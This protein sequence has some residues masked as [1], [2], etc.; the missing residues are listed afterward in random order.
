MCEMRWALHLLPA[1]EALLALFASRRPDVVV[2]GE[3]VRGTSHLSDHL[4]TFAVV[5]LNDFLMI[6]KVEIWTSQR[7][8]QQFK[9][10]FINASTLLPLKESGVVD[11]HLP[12]VKD[13]PLKASV[14]AVSIASG[15][16]PAVSV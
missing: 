5:V 9:P 7:T 12:L 16:Q 14:A 8:G 15:E 10:I 6:K 1:L 13:K 3:D 11:C 2:K 4:F